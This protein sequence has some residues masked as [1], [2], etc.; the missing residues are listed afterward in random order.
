MQLKELVAAMEQLAPTR[1]A[2][3]W[4]NVGLLAGDPEQLVCRAL[5]TIDYTDEV[6][7]EGRQLGCD[8]VI[9]Y[10][11]PI[12]QAIKRIAAGTAL[13]DA[14]RRGVAIYSPHT[15]LDV[16]A[17]GT[18]DVLADAVGM[19]DRRPL[20]VSS[21]KPT[22]VKLVTFVPARDVDR[23]SSVLFAAGAGRIGNYSSCSFRTPG[24]GTF[25]GGEG[26][27]PAIGKAG[28]LETVEEVRLEM[29]V[30]VAGI[31]AVVSALR[32]NHPYEEPAFDLV[33]LAALPEGVGMGRIGGLPDGTTRLSLIGR[34]K[35]ELGLTHLLVAG[36]TDAPAR[37]VAV[38]AGACGDLLDDAIAQGADVYVTGE[39]RHHD[40]LKAARAGMTVVC[41]LHSNSERATLGRLA[42]RIAELLPGLDV[43]VSQRDRDPFAI[44]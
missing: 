15:A 7:E 12:F 5:L 14:L 38:G 17:G 43:R 28:R 1:H 9:A 2:E 22:H 44:A 8:V 33:Q 3:G 36:S 35:A 16:A 27:N 21:G 42:R 37:R 31:E 19:V 11:P 13:H 39:M 25:L 20:R 26:T 10:H 29:V 32:A 40:A 4:D 23:L 18:N 24:T 34:V 41:T 30:P 6:A